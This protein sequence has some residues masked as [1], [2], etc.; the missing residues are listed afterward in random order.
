MESYVRIKF[1]GK[2]LRKLVISKE[3][4]ENDISIV[5]AKEFYKVDGIYNLVLDVDIKSIGGM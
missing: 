3:M 4:G 1:K 2:K 5:T